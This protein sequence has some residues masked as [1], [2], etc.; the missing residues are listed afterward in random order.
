MDD[1]EDDDGL[2]FG[3]S[4]LLAEAGPRGRCL[5]ALGICRTRDLLGPFGPTA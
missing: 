4:I 5:V 3:A 1:E 2:I